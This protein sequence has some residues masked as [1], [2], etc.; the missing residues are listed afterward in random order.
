MVITGGILEEG[1]EEIGDEDVDVPKEFY[2]IVFRKSG[3]EMKALAFLIP[4]KESSAPLK[5]FL[6]PIDTLEARTGLDFF[7]KQPGSWQ[8]GLEKKVNASGWKF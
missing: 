2:K 4:A 5:D 1:L 6:V 8:D 3:K 7:K